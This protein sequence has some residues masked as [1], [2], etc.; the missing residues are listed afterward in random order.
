MWGFG[1]AVQKNADDHAQV[2]NFPHSKTHDDSLVL[3]R[4]TIQYPRKRNHKNKRPGSQRHIRRRACGKN[5]VN[6]RYNRKRPDYSGHPGQPV[7]KHD[8]R[9]LFA[10]PM[11][12]CLFVFVSEAQ[13]MHMLP[14]YHKD[15]K[16]KGAVCSKQKQHSAGFQ[17]II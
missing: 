2:G 4:Q 15:I 3:V 5:A 7:Q 1:S 10:C 12:R 16:A 11:R 9:C 14:C 13:I 8:V 6:L 17:W